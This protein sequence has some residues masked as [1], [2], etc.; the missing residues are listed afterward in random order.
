MEEKNPFIQNTYQWHSFE[1]K[2]A[3][4][5]EQALVWI[6]DDFFYDEKFS[7]PKILSKIEAHLYAIMYILSGKAEYVYVENSASYYRKKYNMETA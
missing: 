2:K 7:R 6:S 5:N 1:M 3:K 4:P